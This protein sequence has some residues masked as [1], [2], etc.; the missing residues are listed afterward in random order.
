V[1]VRLAIQ[2]A[3]QLVDAKEIIMRAAIVGGFSVAQAVSAKNRKMMAVAMG[4]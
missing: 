2:V 4:P 3:V 1:V